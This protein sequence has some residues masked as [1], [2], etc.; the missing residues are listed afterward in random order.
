MWHI[1]GFETKEEAKDY[2][3]TNGGHICWEE[4][5]PKRKQLTE[6]GQEYMIGAQA[7]CMDTVK[8]PYAVVKRV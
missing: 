3:R 4:R 2:Q 6:R 5:T 7:T 8:Y 1:Q